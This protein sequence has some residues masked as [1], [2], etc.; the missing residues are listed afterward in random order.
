M[1]LSKRLSLALLALCPVAAM[2]TS[3]SADWWDLF[4]PLGYIKYDGIDGEA[5]LFDPLE[6]PTSGV[7]I[8]VGSPADTFTE[9]VVLGA[10]IV[11]NP[12]DLPEEGNKSFMDF[13]GNTVPDI[14]SILSAWGTSTGNADLDGNG[15]VDGFDLLA[16]LE[17]QPQSADSSGEPQTG[18]DE[19]WI[20]IEGLDWD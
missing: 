19:D 4:D 6:A 7:G 5:N 18:A 9:P 14:E 16:V 11:G 20:I 12:A 17:L 10:I 15:I 8:V 2:T 3:A 13:E 1:N